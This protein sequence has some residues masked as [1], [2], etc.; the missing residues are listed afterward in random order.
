MAL[1]KISTD[2]TSDIPVNL[3]EELNIE[4]VPLMIIHGDKEY[5]DGIDL[6]TRQFYE[7]LETSDIMPGSSCV[8]LVYYTNLYEKV[9]AD[10][11]TDLI[12]TTINSKG[13]STYQGANM[14]RDQFY[15][16][17][18]EAKEK[19]NIHIIDSTTYSVGY[20]WAV[21]EA[22]RMVKDGKSVEDII[23]Y[24]NDWIA[25]VRP[26][27]LPMNLKFVK[28][29]GRISA[30]AAFVGDALG[31]K[32]VITFEDGASKVIS[33]IRG[34]KRA[35]KEFVDLIE[36]EREVGTPYMLV[37]GNNDEQFLKFKEECA[38]RFER[39]PEFVYDVGNIISIN[40]GPNMIGIIYR[41]K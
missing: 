10:G 16:D 31:L 41:M 26:V 19:F 23:A 3:K 9:Y 6:T 22:A 12:H 39:E 37:S 40:T 32:P 13:S 17:H 30:A 7:I 20:G 11:Y 5:R 21:I 27:M 8:P 36:S 38:L 15:E 24:I 35:V 25:H 18:P 1:I 14:M 33:K 29:S 2:S 28:K 4:V 34:E